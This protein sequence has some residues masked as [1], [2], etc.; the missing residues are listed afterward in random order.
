[1][2]SA[3][4]FFIGCR[5]AADTGGGGGESSG[6]LKLKNDDGAWDVSGRLENCGLAGADGGATDGAPLSGGEEK[7]M[8]W[9]AC[10]APADKIIAPAVTISS[11]HFGTG[12]RKSI[13]N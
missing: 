3:R 1:L 6:T 7:T 5:P 12:R 10:C 11:G 9:P 13:F 4:V 2:R 8:G